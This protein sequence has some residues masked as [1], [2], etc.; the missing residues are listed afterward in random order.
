MLRIRVD[1]NPS[2][3]KTL[4]VWDIDGVL[5]KYTMSDDSGTYD[6][7]GEPVLE[8]IAKLN[9][10]YEDGDHIV[11]WTARGEVARAITESHLKSLGINYHILFM[12][13]NGNI[14]VNDDSEV[15]MKFNHLPTQHCTR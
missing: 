4:R 8:E 14:V 9:K 11:I 2:R 10:Q 1:K 7:C 3:E 6:P 12:N 15:D 5:V 13:K